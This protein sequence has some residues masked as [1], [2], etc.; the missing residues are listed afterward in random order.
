VKRGE[1]GGTKEIGKSEGE[2]RKHFEKKAKT[3][4]RFGR[5]S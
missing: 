3:I 1:K 5:C 2:E 4:L